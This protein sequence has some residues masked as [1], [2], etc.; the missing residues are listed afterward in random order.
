GKSIYFTTADIPAEVWQT[1]VNGGEESAV[2]GKAV[3]HAALAAG[4]DGLYYFSTASNTGAQLDFLRFADRSIHPLATIDR[5]VHTFLS[6]SSDGHS[7]LY[8]Q[9]DSRDHDLMMVDPYR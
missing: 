6:S 8:S 2:I 4:P 3:G 7:V 5:P 1:T 9:I